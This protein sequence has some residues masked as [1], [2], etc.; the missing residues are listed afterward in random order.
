MMN[1][2]FFCRAWR[3]MANLLWALLDRYL[4]W[5]TIRRYE[6]EQAERQEIEDL[7]RRLRA[8]HSTRHQM[9]ETLAKRAAERGDL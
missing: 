2:C 5:C 3:R 7:R 8:W 1:G 9:E 6:R 4:D